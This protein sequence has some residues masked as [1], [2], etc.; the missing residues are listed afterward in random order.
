MRFRLAG[1]AAA[2]LI[3]GG[4][5]F[6]GQA[7]AAPV[8]DPPATDPAQTHPSGSVGPFEPY[9]GYGSFGPFPW[10]PGATSS[11]LVPT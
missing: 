11:V 8:D 3:L 2:A 9:P 4:P 6:A 1:V 10:G 7:W 5:G